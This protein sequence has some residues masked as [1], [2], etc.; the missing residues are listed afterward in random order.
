MLES[1]YRGT[2]GLGAR[3][4]LEA[5]VFTEARAVLAQDEMRLGRRFAWNPRALTKVLWA[6]SRRDLERREN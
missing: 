2:A 5:V 6:M 4:S 3:S 1:G